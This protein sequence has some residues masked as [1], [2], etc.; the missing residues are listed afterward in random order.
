MAPKLV[1]QEQAA[2]A[3]LKQLAL[4]LKKVRRR[5]LKRLSRGDL[6]DLP[7]LY[8]RGHAELA[9]R[10]AEGEPAASLREA[11]SDLARAHGLLHRPSSVGARG[12]R[13][14]RA[15]SF[16]FNDCPRALR[17]E[18]RLAL[19]SVIIVYGL[20]LFGFFAVEHEPSLAY[21]LLD[22]GAVR[23]EISQLESLGEGESFRG[24]FTFGVGESPQT[25]GWIMAHNMSVGILFF[26][27]GLIPPLFLFLMATNGLMLGVYTAVAHSYGQAGAISSILWCHGVVEIQ[28]LVLAGCAGLVLFRGFLR[29]GPYSRAE[30]MARSGRRAWLL[31]AP[32]FPMLFVAGTIEGFVSPHA[33]LEVRLTVAVGTGLMLITWAALGGRDTPAHQVP[34]PTP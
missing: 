9:R 11:E 24:N 1:P 7:R 21:S 8:R 20:A 17:A 6:L 15:G 32:T 3:A 16:L 14:S 22:P 28:A 19:V 12:S 26:A 5:G 13:L 4:L 18:W 31:L 25:A 29:P 30:S 10:R 2:P 33:P 27:A 23:N 34:T